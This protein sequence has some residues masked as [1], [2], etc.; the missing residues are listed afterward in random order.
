MKGIE[1]VVFDIAGTTVRDNGNVAKAFLDACK[2]FGYTIEKEEVQHVMGF[3]KIDA[4]RMLLDKFY[5]DLD[6]KDEQIEK[7]HEAFTRNMINFYESDAVL[8]PLPFAEDIFIWLKK[9]G[10]K[11]ALNTGF[12]KPITDTILKRLEWKSGSTIDYVISSDETPHGRPYPDM[13]NAIMQKLDISDPA[14][15]AKVG[16][17]EVDVEEGRHAQCGLVISVTTGAY[18]RKKLEQY[19]PDYI[20]DSLSELPTIIESIQ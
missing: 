1:L 7:I 6:N 16:D 12:T 13:I 20:I 9:K 2:T 17:T 5:P 10:V 19:H 14:A 11:L 18:S 3:R 8:Q 4:I 15:V